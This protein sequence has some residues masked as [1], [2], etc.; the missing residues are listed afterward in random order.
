[1]PSATQTLDSRFLRVGDCFAQRF[2]TPGTFRYALSPL[3]SSLAAHHDE[4]PR[5]AVVVAAGESV[6]DPKQHHAKDD[7]DRRTHAVTVSLSNGTL[8][9]SP[10]ILEITAG[11]VVVWGPD[12]SVTF[13]FRVRG[14]LGEQ[15]VDSA[16]LH[17]ESVFTHAFGLPGTYEWVDANGSGLHGRVEVVSPANMGVDDVERWL[18]TLQEGTLVHVTG[19]RAE[20][21]A[22]Q[23]VLGQTVVWAVEEAPGVTI[24]DRTLLP[25]QSVGVSP[26]RG[27]R[28][29]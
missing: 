14:R 7:H 11:D 24:T 28:S 1:M 10:A 29:R 17:T 27:R 23:I 16:A 20:P 26:R 25:D 5:L 6:A 22:V 2:S 18:A 8:E 15:T 19:H 3:P 9:A 12:R 13:G 21:E 4:P